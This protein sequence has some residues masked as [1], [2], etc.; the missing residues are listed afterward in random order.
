MARKPKMLN[1]LLTHDEA[2][3]IMHHISFQK[4]GEVKEFRYLFLQAFSDVLLDKVAQQMLSS[5]DM[6]TTPKNKQILITT[7]G[8][9]RTTLNF[10][11]WYPNEKNR[12]MFIP[13]WGEGRGIQSW[14][15]SSSI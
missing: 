10:Q 15:G 1:I 6:L 9:M 11:P 8:L 2:K 5:S 13:R 14:P 4:G 12:L 7:K 3:R